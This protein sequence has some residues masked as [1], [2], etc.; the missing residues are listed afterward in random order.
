[1]EKVYVLSLNYSVT[2]IPCYVYD[3]YA[4]MVADALKPYGGQA[5]NT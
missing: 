1:M 4:M 5:F 3:Y 2:I